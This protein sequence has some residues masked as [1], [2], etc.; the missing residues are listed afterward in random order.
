[1]RYQTGAVI[2]GSSGG[3][4]NVLGASR[5]KC[6]SEGTKIKKKNA[7]NVWFLPFFSCWLG[8]EWGI[9]LLTRGK[10]P[11][12]PL[13]PPLIGSKYQGWQQNKLSTRFDQRGYSKI[14][15][16][17]N[18]S[19]HFVRITPLQ[20]ISVTLNGVSA[21]SSIQLCIFLVVLCLSTES[22]RPSNK[23]NIPPVK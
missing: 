10:C 19:V 16:L 22:M 18:Y 15:V 21:D 8:V 9:D 14:P 11:S 4:K 2:V 13:V 3:T 12:L 7:E 23:P 20:R 17:T 5:G 6:I 1:M